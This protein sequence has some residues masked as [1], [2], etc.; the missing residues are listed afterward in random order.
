MFALIPNCPGRRDCSCGTFNSTSQLFFDLRD[1]ILGQ[2][3]DLHC[4]SV[5]L[6][7]GIILKMHK[8]AHNNSLI[9]IITIV[10]NY[11]IYFIN[12]IIYL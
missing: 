8:D 7:L 11:I 1:S 3:R 2:K 12:K 5:K 10:N 6:M 4:N 9:L